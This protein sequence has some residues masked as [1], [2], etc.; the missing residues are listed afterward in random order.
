MIAPNSTSFTDVNTT[1]GTTY[2]YQVRAANDFFA[3][4]YTN[5]ASA[6]TGP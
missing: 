2:T 5:E 1:A 4:A 3:S 6:T